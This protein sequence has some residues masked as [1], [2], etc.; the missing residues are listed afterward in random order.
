MSIEQ[1]ANIEVDTNKLKNLLNHKVGLGVK[2]Q[3]LLDSDG[4]LIL[5]V[6]F[7]NLENDIRDKDDYKSLEDFKADRR[8]V[9][10]IKDALSELESCVGDAEQASLELKKLIEAESSTP[11]LL[12]LDGEGMDNEEG[13]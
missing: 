11:S 6:I 12:S 4:F 2:V 10:I 3:Q 1:N 13:Q 9:K 5:K 8:A 7:K